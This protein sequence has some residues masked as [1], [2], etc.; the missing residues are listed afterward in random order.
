M[1]G[2]IHNQWYAL[3]SIMF[4]FLPKICQSRCGFTWSEG[5]NAFPNVCALRVCPKYS[6]LEMARVTGAT[7]QK[8]I[9]IIFSSRTLYFVRMDGGSG[10]DLD[11]T[12]PL[13]LHS[14]GN[15]APVINYLRL[16]GSV[17]AATSKSGYVEQPIWLAR[18]TINS[19]CH[20]AVWAT[21]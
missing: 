21:L 11:R 7:M 19:S 10:A 9:P 15:C 6:K 13:S 18:S 14:F 2:K 12:R 16:R 8:M 1:Y 3:A 4:G 20:L 5:S 17:L